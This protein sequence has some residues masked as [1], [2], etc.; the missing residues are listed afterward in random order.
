M[1]VLCA[2]AVATA[3]LVWWRWSPTTQPRIDVGQRV[4]EEFLTLL[5]GGQADAAWQSTTAEFKSAL[6]REK[7][8]LFVKQRA[9]FKRPLSFVSMQTVRVQNRPRSEFVYRT[10]DNKATIRVLVGSESGTW[11]VDRLNV[12]DVPH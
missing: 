8:L 5:R 6:G 1:S 2:L 12:D 7:F 3:V 4:V 10:A 9:Y 11:H